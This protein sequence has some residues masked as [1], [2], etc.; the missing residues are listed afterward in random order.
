GAFDAVVQ[1]ILEDLALD[2]REGR[3]DGAGL[4][5]DVDAIA[6]ILDHAGHAAHLSLDAVQAVE[7][8]GLVVA[9]Q[10]GVSVRGDPIEG[11]RG[12]QD[13]PAGYI[14][15]PV[16]TQERD[17]SGPSHPE[18]TSHAR[19]G[20]GPDCGH[21]ETAGEGAAMAPVCGMMVDTHAT[22]HRAEHAGRTYYSCSAGCRTKFVADPGKYL[23]D[24]AD[25]PPPPP[26]TSYTCPMHPEVRQVGPG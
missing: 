21:G 20:H 2:P 19:G 16:Q 11:G 26:G 13:T 6:I 4:G 17:M 25:E 24:R 18:H 1:V 10:G 5:Q 22:A 8:G 15:R 14:S 9:V 3:A 23:G 7:Q 12:L